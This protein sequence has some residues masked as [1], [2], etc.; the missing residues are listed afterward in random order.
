M[1]GQLSCEHCGATEVRRYPKEHWNDH[2]RWL[3]RPCIIARMIIGQARDRM[4]R[5]QHWACHYPQHFEQPLLPPTEVV[6]HRLSTARSRT[7][8]R[9]LPATLNI[10][11]WNYIVT[12]FDN[13]CAYCGDPWEQIEHATAICRGGGTTLANCL[14]ACERCNS[15]KHQHSLEYL[16]AK[17]LWPHQTARLEHALTWL[18][19]HGRTPD[20]PS[21]PRVPYGWIPSASEAA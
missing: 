5:V 7:H 21:G 12:F 11:G 13:R 2:D 8:Q 19:N 4:R 18:Q 9:R 14:P 1:R 6:K 20:N 10:A 15:M 16:L 3:C 17:D